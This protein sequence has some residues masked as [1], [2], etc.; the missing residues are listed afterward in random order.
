MTLYQKYYAMNTALNTALVNQSVV[1]PVY[2][3]GRV[4]KPAIQPKHPYMQS[5]YR[6]IQRQP[7]GSAISGTLTDFEYM[8]NFFT[9]ASHED[10]NDAALFIP[11]E[12]ARELIV[13][14]DYLIWR[15][16]ANVLNHDETPE[17]NFKGGLEVI[18]KGLV[19]RC[20]T[21]VSHVI[22]DSTKY[23]SEDDAMEVV[24]DSINFE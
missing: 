16:I 9:A 24:E 8:L 17:F 15:S 19:F 23:V 10:S 18:Q 11:Y 2:K 4:T 20:Q 5:T 14:P 1:C 7:N 22:T 13:S 6:V 12:T 3:Y 21:V